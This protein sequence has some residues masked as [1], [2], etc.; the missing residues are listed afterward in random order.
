MCV[1]MYLGC[2]V[3][4]C[5][6]KFWKVKTRIKRAFP[7]KPV[8]VQRWVWPPVNGLNQILP[9]HSCHDGLQGGHVSSPN[10]CTKFNKSEG[11]E[12]Q[13]NV[14]VCPH[15]CSCAHLLLA[16]S[17]QCGHRSQFSA[18]GVLGFWREP[19]G[20][21]R[22]FKGIFHIFV[23][24]GTWQTSANQWPNLNDGRRHHHP[25]SQPWK[26]DLIVGRPSCWPQPSL[27]KGDGWVSLL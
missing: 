26:P 11:G 18:I 19:R 16:R 3:V 25:Q 23:Y 7:I 9:Q 27:A 24:P 1:C 14:Q 6:A 10:F 21:E 12:Y 17:S 22:V 8:L 15:H 20:G 13:E 5:A 4:V 2:G